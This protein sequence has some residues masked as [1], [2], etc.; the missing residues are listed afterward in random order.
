M[1]PTLAS[2]RRRRGSAAS[3]SVSSVTTWVID[4]CSSR[5]RNSSGCSSNSSAA[6]AERQQG[7]QNSHR[8]RQ[9]RQ[10]QGRPRAVDPLP[11]LSPY[12]FDCDL[13]HVDEICTEAMAPSKLQRQ[14]Q[15]SQ[16]QSLVRKKTYTEDWCGDAT[17]AA[18]PA[19]ITS[20]EQ[21]LL[22]QEPLFSSTSFERHLLQQP[23][24]QQSLRLHHHGHY[25]NHHS[26]SHIADQSRAA[27]DTL[28]HRSYGDAIIDSSSE[29]SSVIS[30]ATN[31]SSSYKEGFA[32]ANATAN[33]DGT[34]MI[35]FS[36]R[37]SYYDDHNDKHH[38]GDARTVGRRSSSMPPPVVRRLSS[39]W[40]TPSTNEA[41]AVGV[42]ESGDIERRASARSQDYQRLGHKSQFFSA[43]MRDIQERILDIECSRSSGGGVDDDED[44]KVDKA[45]IVDISQRSE[46]NCSTTICCST[47]SGGVDVSGRSE[48]TVCGGTTIC[49]IDGSARSGVSSYRRSSG[50]SNSS[51]NSSC[52]SS[53]AEEEEKSYGENYHGEYY[54]SDLEGEDE[55]ERGDDDEDTVGALLSSESLTNK[56]Q[57]DDEEDEGEGEDTIGALLS[58]V[59]LSNRHPL[60]EAVDERGEDLDEEYDIGI[61]RNNLVVSRSSLNLGEIS[62]SSIVSINMSSD[63]NNNDTSA[64]SSHDDG[65]VDGGES[66][67][68]TNAITSIRKVRFDDDDNHCE[69]FQPPR[70]SP[71]P[72]SPSPTPSA[73]VN[74]IIYASIEDSMSRQLEEIKKRRER[75]L[76]HREDVS[77]TKVRA[78]IPITQTTTTEAHAAEHLRDFFERRGTHDSAATATSAS[79][80]SSRTSILEHAPLEVH[81]TSLQKRR[82]KLLEMVEEQEQSSDNTKKKRS[83]EFSLF[84]IKDKLNQLQDLGV[85]GDDDEEEIVKSGGATLLRKIKSEGAAAAGSKRKEQIHSLRRVRS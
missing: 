75:L 36:R 79:S 67:F 49:C 80:A 37:S 81:L 14:Q 77:T 48:R 13:S 76:Q 72:L 30:T 44:G 59:L 51:S 85:L 69:Q 52:R 53:H 50:S 15:R 39:S 8:T 64:A 29:H 74:S 63:T 83:I 65:L 32:F 41:A 58:S 19:A 54:S 34:S 47:I 10:R 4:H 20:F 60:D 33:C 3:V 17:T 6:I 25:N 62:T 28:A 71:P 68:T 9:M 11:S 18:G 7:C 12:S 70:P 22:Q 78:V 26:I 24:L 35:Y 73:D 5:R 84:L 61:Q 46:S 1:A 45:Y 2:P 66:P 56:H 38:C 31:C 55:E 23:E 27:D 21:Q 43:R 82:S 16:S 42:G 40:C 57:C